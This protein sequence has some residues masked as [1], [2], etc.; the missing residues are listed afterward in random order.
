[1]AVIKHGTVRGYKSGCRC[2]D[3]R[4]AN[5]RAKRD[6]RERKRQ[7]EGKAPARPRAAKGRGPTASKPSPQGAPG[8]PAVSRRPSSSGADE[9]VRLIED[10][11]FEHGA[12]AGAQVAAER[13]RELGYRPVEDGPIEAAFRAAF[14]SPPASEL[15]RAR[16]EVVFAAARNM[17][18]PKHAPFFK[19]NAEVLRLHVSDLLADAPEKDG[20]A[21]DIK[22]LLGTFGSRGGARRGAPVGD[23]KES[24]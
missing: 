19:S 18:S 4:E 14:A 7:R 8:D 11:V 13:L 3:C 23:A 1:M 16:R 20:E 6:E 17:D 9:M 12:I 2:D 5:T 21:D 15:A 24:Q 22:E 10:A